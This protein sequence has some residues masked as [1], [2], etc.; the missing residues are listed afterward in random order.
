MLEFNTCKARK[1]AISS[2]FHIID[3]KKVQIVLLPIGLVRIQVDDL[4]KL[5]RHPFNIRK[6]Q[7]IRLTKYFICRMKE[8]TV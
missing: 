2:T 7:N 3:Q 4:L 5:E 6:N 8:L 1:T